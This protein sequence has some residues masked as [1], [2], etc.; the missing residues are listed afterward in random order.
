MIDFM[1]LLVKIIE[2]DI[3]AAK[4]Q[5]IYYYWR[6]SSQEFWILSD[7]LQRIEQGSFK[8]WFRLTELRTSITSSSS[9][10]SYN[11]ALTILNRTY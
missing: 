7:L 8:K 9:Y 6:R 1:P 10:S 3:D 5:L 11:L 2:K 4:T